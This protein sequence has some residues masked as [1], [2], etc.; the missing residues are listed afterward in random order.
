MPD[1][2][3]LRI[4]SRYT[5][6]SCAYNRASKMNVGLLLPS[7]LVRLV[8]CSLINGVVIWRGRLIVTSMDGGGSYCLHGCCSTT[9]PLSSAHTRTAK[10]PAALLRSSSSM[11]RS[12]PG[13]SPRS[14]GRSPGAIAP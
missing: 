5:E 11:S 1:S 13:F 3:R 12:D 8:V 9:T 6:D 14:K 7:S 2:I 10:R 4:N